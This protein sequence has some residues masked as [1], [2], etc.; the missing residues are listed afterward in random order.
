MELGRTIGLCGN[1]GWR[2]PRRANRRSEQPKLA[3][4]YRPQLVGLECRQHTGWI[5]I[6]STDATYPHTESGF[7]APPNKTL[8]LLA[9]GLMARRGLARARKQGRIDASS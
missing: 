3:H 6:D 5:E 4:T 9:N 7:L 1:L 2:R 8:L